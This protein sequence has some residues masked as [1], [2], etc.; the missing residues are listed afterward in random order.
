MKIFIHFNNCV[1]SRNYYF[2]IRYYIG[3]LFAATNY[4]KF[5]SFRQNKFIIS[6]FEVELTQLIFLLELSKAEF[7]VLTHWVSPR[8]STSRIVQV[9]GRVHFEIV[10]LKLPFITDGRCHYS[11]KPFSSCCMW[12]QHQRSSKGM[13]S[14]FHSWNLSNSTSATSTYRLRKFSG[15]F[16]QFRPTQILI[17]ANLVTCWNGHHWERLFCLPHVHSFN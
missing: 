3:F 2:Q 14:S 6:H 10:E 11:S 9:G 12:P 15:F 16:G 13:S 17:P 1:E 4:H 5:S 8:E 7:R